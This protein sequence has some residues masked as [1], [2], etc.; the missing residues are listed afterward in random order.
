MEKMQFVILGAGRPYHGDDPS[1]LI[2]TSGHK[3]VLDWLL[4]IINKTFVDK[5]ANIYFVGGYKIDEVIK[6]YPH[7]NFS[8]NENWEKTGTVATLL[9][10]SLEEITTFVTYSDI[11][12]SD[13]ILH[14]MENENA[15][16]VVAVD[17]NW[18]GRYSSRDIEDLNKAEKAIIKNGL[19]CDIGNHI[20]IDKANAEFIGIIKL[21]AKVLAYIKNI[22]KDGE[23]DFS[24][25][26]IPFLIKLLAEKGFD[27]RTV[28]I[29]SSW[30]ELNNKKDLSQF[31]IGSK[32]ETLDNL[33]HLATKSIIGEQIRFTVKEWLSNEREKIHDVKKQFTNELL[34]VRSSAMCEDG[35]SSSCAGQYETVLNVNPNNEKELIE[36][37]NKVVSSYDREIEENQI[38]VQK[39]VKNV[40]YSGVILTRTLTAG[41]PYYV[42]NY[43]EDANDT[44]AV[45]SGTGKK[46]KSIL[47]YKNINLQNNETIYFL[48]PL[49][50][51][52]KELEE[53]TDNDALDIEF[54]ITNDNKVHIF[55]L[56]PITTLNNFISVSDT[57]FDD[58]IKG[59]RS[60]FESKQHKLPHLI[61]EKT[62][63]GVMPDWNPAEII[64]TKPKPLSASLYRYLI[65]DETWATQRATFGYR[66]VRP[67]PLLSFFCGHPYVDIRASFNSFIPKEINEK[68]A[69]KLFEYYIE[70]LIKNPHFHD[71]VEFDILFT[72][73]TFDYDV[74]KKKELIDAGFDEIEILE[75][76][77]ALLKIT[78]DAFLNIDSFFDEIEIL[79]SKFNNNM[80][81]SDC[82]ALEQA[83]LLLDECK[84][85]GTLPFAHLARCGFIAVA[86]LKSL[87][88][89][90]VIDELEKDSFLKS[91]ET[92]A[93]EFAH[94]SYKF[95]AGEENEEDF[96]KKY[97][98]LRPGTYE[99][100]SPSYKQEPSRYL[101][102]HKKIKS[103]NLVKVIDLENEVSWDDNTRGR[104]KDFIE[105]INFNVTV[106]KLEVFLKK[107]IEGREYSK[108]IFSRNLSMALDNIVEFGEEIGLTKDDLS[109]LTIDDL[110]KFNINS[111]STNSINMLKKKIEHRKKEYRITDAVELPP[112]ICKM[113]DILVFERP[114]GLPNFVT[115]NRIIADILVIDPQLKYDIKD[116]EGKIVMLTNADPGYDWLF[117]YNIAG[118]ITM[119]GGANSHM[120]I[121]TAELNIPAAIGVG[122]HFYEE[123]SG[124]YIVDLNCTLRQLKVVR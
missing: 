36:A 79:K 47:I 88:S 81:Y 43:D 78:E 41:A 33:K 59:A 80:K 114:V 55:Q 103:K 94:D 104:I 119:Y 116:I 72:C 91:L 97:G 76:K 25:W 64:G 52:V 9:T 23:K 8:V 60:F 10:P 93:K 14:K 75:L 66:D 11:V 87:V 122:E 82:L 54:A 63:F 123:L 12:L 4:D 39:M 74:S 15:A 107:A 121:R 24:K 108:F 96:V 46:I 118:L 113:D 17:Y 38:F 49:L 2:L 58:Y 86:L 22:K 101:K 110:F 21:D 90:R 1:A 30:S 85:H 19:L 70:K 112:L 51:A 3:R 68:L 99:I 50:E 105:S 44:T 13:N 28:S 98:H 53:I 18:K 71:K 5:T 109:Y 31:I 35:I 62:I 65:M 29:D 111:N 67:A 84:R 115:N 106:E 34:A 102:G 56:R 89:M 73:Y 95:S 32:A 100:T 57:L 69:E 27:V 120:T 92:V 37:I 26:N 48:K 83:M 20:P 124:A 77:N 45:T 40:S 61:G 16:V 7:L 42:L 6:E 117:G